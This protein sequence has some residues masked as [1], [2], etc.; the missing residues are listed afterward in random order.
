LRGLVRLADQAEVVVVFRDSL[1]GAVLNLGRTKRC[2]SK[3]QT[4]ALYARDK[5]CSFPGCD[6]PP[7][8]CERHH[9]VAWLFGGLTDIDN[10]TL[11]CRYHHHSFERLGWT[12]RMEAG[13]PVW[14][15]PRY[16]D[17]A[18]APMINNRIRP[19]ILTTSP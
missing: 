13:I 19:P 7:Q 9:V 1:T 6:R 3:D 15:P 11:V 14:Y 2:A 16:L 8:W 18:R 17:R 12:C 10:L 4:L 5:G